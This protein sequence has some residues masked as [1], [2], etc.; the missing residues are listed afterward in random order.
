[1]WETSE[2][3]KKKKKKKEDFRSSYHPKSISSISSIPGSYFGD[4]L[5]FLFFICCHISWCWFQEYDDCCMPLELSREDLVYLSCLI[6]NLSGTRC[7]VVFTYFG[8]FHAKS[9]VFLLCVWSS[10]L[11][12]DWVDLILFGGRLGFLLFFPIC[13]LPHRFIRVWVGVVKRRF[14]FRIYVYAVVTH[15]TL[16]VHVKMI[17]NN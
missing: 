9:L 12:A 16:P 13:L 15:C 10:L 2:K 7:P 3:W 8:V 5:P 1:M 14:C 6:V 17:Q 4:I 11:P